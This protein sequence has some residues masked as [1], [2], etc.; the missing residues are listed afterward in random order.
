M[1]TVSTI[2]ITDILHFNGDK[3]Y[4]EC[5]CIDSNMDSLILYCLVCMKVNQTETFKTR[6]LKMSVLVRYWLSTLLKCQAL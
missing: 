1:H 3:F 5:P 2:Q 6:H 4:M